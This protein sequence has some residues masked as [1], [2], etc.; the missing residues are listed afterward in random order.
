VMQLYA[1]LKPASVQAAAGG[2]P[3]VRVRMEMGGAV[4]R[5]NMPSGIPLAVAGNQVASDRE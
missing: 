2:R 1:V 4:G 5:G 3:P